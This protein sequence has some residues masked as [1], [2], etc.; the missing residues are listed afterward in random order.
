MT[1][2]VICVP[3]VLNGATV[4]AGRAAP[5]W[6]LRRLSGALVRRMT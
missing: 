1:G 6:S 3:G 4:V 5:K 2:D